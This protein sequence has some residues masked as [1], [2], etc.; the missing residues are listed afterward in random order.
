MDETVFFNPGD[1]I[2]NFHDH[3]EAVKAAQIYKERDVQD[4]NVLVVH[5][6]DNKSFD[7]F[8]ADDQIT[9]GNETAKQKKA[10]YK[11]TDKI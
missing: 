5:G 8:L 10:A 9:H 11:L 1:S 2:G 3:N 4:K 7:V 6:K